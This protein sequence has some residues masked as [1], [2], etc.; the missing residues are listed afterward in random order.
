MPNDVVSQLSFDGGN[1]THD[2]KDSNAQPKTLSTPIVV[3][4]ATCTTVESALRAINEK[5]SGGSIGINTVDTDNVM[6]VT[7]S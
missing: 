6:L 5:P 3:D 7:F 2:I 4:N 1:T